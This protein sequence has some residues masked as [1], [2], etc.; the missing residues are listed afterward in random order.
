MNDKYNYDEG[1]PHHKKKGNLQ[2]KIFKFVILV[3]VSIFFYFIISFVRIQFFSNSNIDYKFSMNTDKYTYL[4]N[5]DKE[6]YSLH[7]D[8]QECNLQNFYMKHVAESLPCVVRGFDKE[9]FEKI[10]KVLKGDRD[11]DNIAP[12]EDK[13]IKIEDAEGKFGLMD[14]TKTMSFVD[15]HLINQSKK[16]N[17]IVEKA[18]LTN[19]EIIILQIEGE[20]EFMISP[21]SQINKLQP[22]RAGEDENNISVD[23]FNP[24]FANENLFELYEN[25]EKASFEDRV[26]IFKVN[27]SE[28][29]MLYIPAYFFKQTKTVN[30]NDKDNR[31][32][33]Q[34]FMPSS[35]IIST[36]Y[37]VLFDDNPK[38]TE[39]Y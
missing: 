3:I 1:H 6:Y 29:D 39:H 17:D 2:H 34:E 36:M 25:N 38:L 10:K 33:N 20:R 35:R 9:Y 14:F 27:I 5:I 26:V 37:K 16:S 21:I 13:I 19:K 12:G 18:G 11:E 24:I 30:V 22:H 7:K 8:I 4:E 32:I 28:G 15:A 23:N 31:V